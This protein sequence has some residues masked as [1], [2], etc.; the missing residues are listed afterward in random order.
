MSVFLKEP[1]FLQWKIV[2]RDHTQGT[3]SIH[4]CWISH[5]FQIFSLNSVRTLFLCFCFF[6]FLKFLIQ[7]LK[8]TLHLQLLQNIGYVPCVV[9]YIFVACLTPNSL[10]LPLLHSYILPPTYILVITNLCSVLE[11]FLLRQNTEF[12]LNQIQDHMVL[13]NLMDHLF[14]PPSPKSHCP[15]TPVQLLNSFIPHYINI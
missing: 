15:V 13:H 7:F 1:W 8:V 2:L 6:F 11:I 9:Q 3:R 14:F 4:C 12:I 10:Y 5:F